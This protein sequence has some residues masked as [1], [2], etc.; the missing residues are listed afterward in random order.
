MIMEDFNICLIWPARD[1]IYSMKPKNT[2]KHFGGYNEVD[3]WRDIYPFSK[4]HSKAKKTLL[5]KAGA[6]GLFLR[7]RQETSLCLGNSVAQIFLTADRN[8]SNE[9]QKSNRRRHSHL[10]FVC[11]ITADKEVERLRMFHRYHS[12]EKIFSQ[13]PF[14][15]GWRSRNDI[16]ARGAQDPGTAG[17]E[18]VS[19]AG[20]AGAGLAVAG[21][22]LS[23]T[24]TGWTIETHRGHLLRLARK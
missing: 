1:A 10:K 13:G 7:R 5:L 22:S 2:W 23:I 21:S 19:S 15:N 6:A 11:L 12:R 9:V 17:W 3:P 16:E 20:S 4:F 8:G 24:L 14:W 18:T